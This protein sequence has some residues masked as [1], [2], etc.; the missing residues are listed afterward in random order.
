MEEDENIMFDEMPDMF[1]R[2]FIGNTNPSKSESVVSHKTYN[3]LYEELCD[4]CFP[5]RFMQPYDAQKVS[6]A[7]KLY[8]DVLQSMNDQDKQNEL[9]QRAYKELG[10]KFD[11]THLYN[12]LMDYLNPR[13]YLN[14]FTPDKLEIANRYY[15]SIE[16]NK[17]DYIA[18]ESIRSDVQWFIDAINEKR[19]A[20]RK[21]QEEALMN[22]EQLAMRRFEEDKQ[23][24]DDVRNSLG[25]ENWRRYVEEEYGGYIKL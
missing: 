23:W 18:L 25:E 4:K 9:R 20:E 10:V 12:Y 11:G 2:M 17:A 6:I 8:S 21:E 3:S 16:E 22:E 19:E 13:V 5:E 7:T 15:P 1:G 14:P 24:L